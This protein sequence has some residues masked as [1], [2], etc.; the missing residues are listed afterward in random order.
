MPKVKAAMRLAQAIVAT[1]Y[2]SKM[3]PGDRYLSEAD[4]LQHHRV[5]RGT[6]REALRFLEIQGVVNIRA[7]P[8]GGPELLR[9]GWPQLASTIALLLQFAD[10]PMR[11]V[12]EARTAIEPGVARMAAMH[13]TETDID[14]MAKD[15][16][17]IEFQIGN[18][19]KWSPAYLQYWNHLAE[20]THNSFLMFVSP[21]LRAIVNSAG[22]VPNEP[23]RVE[24]LGRL[25]VIHEAVAQHDADA[26]GEAMVELEHEFF[27]R[28]SSGYPRQMERV[29]AWSD[30]DLDV[31]SDLD[32]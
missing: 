2:E 30:L 23:Y 14:A 31:D 7:G 17:E 25:R 24:T 15:L 5:A 13:A 9:P 1:I 26:A 29:V 22:F 4:A 21:A 16:A 28:L 8:G 32:P 6:Y 19:K 12:L 18:F 10:A 3:R 11:E 20:S 27:A